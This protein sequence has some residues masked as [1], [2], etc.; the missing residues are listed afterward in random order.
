M[1]HNFHSCESY[2]LLRLDIRHASGSIG[3]FVRAQVDYHIVNAREDVGSLRVIYEVSLF[4]P[5]FRCELIF[6][7]HAL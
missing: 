6:P 7:L 5:T 3:N 2:D 4:Y 1:N